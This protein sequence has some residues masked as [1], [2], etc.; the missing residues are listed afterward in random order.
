MRPAEDT[1]SAPQSEE[2]FRLTAAVVGLRL[3]ASLFNIFFF[4]FPPTS[5]GQCAKLKPFSH[6]HLQ[7]AGEPIRSC[8]WYLQLYKAFPLPAA[9]PTGRLTVDRLSAP[10]FFFLRL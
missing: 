1:V 5:D 6:H 4:I 9:R 10:F 7:G 8:F 3:P 2:I